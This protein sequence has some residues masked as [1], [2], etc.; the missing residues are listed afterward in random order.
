M[1]R[2]T[3]PLFNF[4]FRNF[5]ILYSV[6]PDKSKYLVCNSKYL[7]LKDLISTSIETDLSS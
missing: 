6:S 5:L 2:V 3:E 1:L 7:E 4:S